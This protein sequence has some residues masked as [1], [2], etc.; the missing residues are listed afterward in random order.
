M[1]FARPAAGDGE[2]EAAEAAG[3]ADAAGEAATGVGVVSRGRN[4]NQAMTVRTTSTSPAATA[5]GHR[6][7]LCGCVAPR[8]SKTPRPPRRELS[9]GAVSAEYAQPRSA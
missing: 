6:G 1:T 4:T 8:T 3:A 5:Y 7:R 9:S 2:P